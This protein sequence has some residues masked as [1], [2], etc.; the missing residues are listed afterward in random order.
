MNTIY[1]I[2]GF[3]TQ[4]DCCFEW[5]VVAALSQDEAQAA[6]DK[7]QRLIEFERQFKKQQDEQAVPK[8]MQ[9]ENEQLSRDYMDSIRVVKPKK[10]CIEDYNSHV[11][12]INE[13]RDKWIAD[14]YHLPSE[15]QEGWLLGEKERYD[16]LSADY[17][18]VELLCL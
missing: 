15:F 12:L 17:E 4:Y 18:I 10:N 16:Y 2:Q 13:T 3:V 11:N 7:L 6:L 1:I 14:N 8:E 9:K 5:N